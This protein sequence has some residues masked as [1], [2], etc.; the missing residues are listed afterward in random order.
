MREHRVDL[1]WVLSSSIRCDDRWSRELGGGK[2]LASSYS[3]R[4]ETACCLRYVCCVRMRTIQSSCN[5]A[6]GGDEGETSP[7]KTPTAGRRDEI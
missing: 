5:A 2:W 6:D 1:D 7:K 3:G 4:G